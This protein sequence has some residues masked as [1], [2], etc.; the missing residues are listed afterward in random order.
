MDLS[1]KLNFLWILISC[2]YLVPNQGIEFNFLNEFNSKAFQTTYEIFQVFLLFSFAISTYCHCCSWVFGQWR[3]L[4]EWTQS[5]QEWEEFCRKTREEGLINL[6]IVLNQ[7]EVWPFWYKILKLRFL[8]FLCGKWSVRFITVSHFF[9]C[10]NDYFLL[11]FNVLFFNRLKFSYFL[12]WS[13]AVGVRNF[14]F[15]VTKFSFCINFF[16][17]LNK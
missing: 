7:E 13:L 17:L 14:R 16:I 8:L 6:K 4:K 1:K 10:D 5:W 15:W 3:S 9:L 12:F 2:H 11:L